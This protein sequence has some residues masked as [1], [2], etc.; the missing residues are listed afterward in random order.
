VEKKDDYLLVGIEDKLADVSYE[1]KTKVLLKTHQEERTS[2]HQICFEVLH[3]LVEQNHGVSLPDNDLV[4]ISS[5][6]ETTA[7]LRGDL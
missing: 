7:S 6:N 4:I 2:A 1:V 5:P 3:F